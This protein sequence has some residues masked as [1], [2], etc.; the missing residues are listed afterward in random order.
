MLFTLTI[1]GYWTVKPHALLR[2][3]ELENKASREWPEASAD[4]WQANPLIW[5][6]AT[7]RGKAPLRGKDRP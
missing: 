7:T 1:S 5:L 4:K 6:P 2:S 3:D